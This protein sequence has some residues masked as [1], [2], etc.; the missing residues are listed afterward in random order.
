MRIE[1]VEQAGNTVD[2]PSQ[3]EGSP[4]GDAEQE[5]FEV[6]SVAEYRAAVDAVYRDY[7]IEQGCARVR[8]IEENTVSPAMRRIESEDPTRHLVGFD[9]RLKGED[10]LS[11]KVTDAMEER[12]W[13]ATEAFGMVKDAIRYTFQYSDE[14]YAEGVRTDCN[15]LRDSG[16]DPIDRKNTWENEEYKG[17]NTRWRDSGSG[18]IFEVQFH[19]EASF[20]A[21]QETHAAYEKL[22]SHP[23]DD[24]EVHRLR[25]SQRE[26][27]A[28][29]PVPPGA[30]DITSYR[31]EA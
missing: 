12:G 26:V 21:K 29:V 18:Q 24:N 19:T 1:E 5:D 14:G 7:A 28:R 15:R 17:I 23:E 13:S 30:T 6:P 27:T 22:R 8:E 25:A 11:E 9:Y 3:R 16:F 4:D 20:E 31:R 2:L 10:R